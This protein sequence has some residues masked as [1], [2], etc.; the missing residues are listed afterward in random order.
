MEMS[1]GG[2]NVRFIA[3]RPKEDGTPDILGFDVT[4]SEF[5]YTQNDTKNDLADKNK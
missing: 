3:Y 1:I 4:R 2:G 5:E